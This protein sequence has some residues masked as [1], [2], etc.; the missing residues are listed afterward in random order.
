MSK[1]ALPG[2]NGATTNLKRTR[3][4]LWIAA[5]AY[6]TSLLIVGVMIPVVASFIAVGL[7]LT[8]PNSP[9]PP[10]LGLQS[11]SQWYT[12][13]YS[14]FLTGIL[15]LLA[16]FP[17][18]Y[19]STAQAA[20]PRNYGLLNCR[21]RQLKASLGLKDWA[22]GAYE[23]I[24]TVKMV[25]EHA[26]FDENNKHQ[27]EVVKEAYACCID[28]SRKLY[29]CSVG[30]PWIIGTGYN[31]VW[32]LLHH[33]EE[34]MIEVADVETTVRGA[35][36]DF[37]AIQGSQIDGKDEL[38]EDV[39]QAVTVLQPE[40]LAYFKEHQPSKSSVVLS[41]LTQLIHQ[42]S[43]SSPSGNASD[44]SRADTGAQAQAEAMAR[45]TLREVRSTLNDFRDKRWE[46]L[47]RQRI[48][49]LMS[50]AVTGIVTH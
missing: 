25:I 32:T 17:Y 30:L 7:Y 6:S 45:V 23:E 4:D 31:S 22:D 40:A 11:S 15:W 14:S 2:N 29:T 47:V 5:K 36:H 38:L 35:K 12:L 10:F 26:G 18:C 20:N 1:P 39:I 48:R 27:W 42:S 16:A 24:N 8:L 19:L 37:L 44:R 46:G 43:D 33:A 49:L 3:P 13:V 34:A 9:L 28:I 50:I 21:L 41:Q